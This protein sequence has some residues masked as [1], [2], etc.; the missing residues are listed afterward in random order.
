MYALRH[1]TTKKY[2][3]RQIFEDENRERKDDATFYQ[4]REEQVG[5]FGVK[6]RTQGKNVLRV[7]GVHP[8]DV[9]FR[10]L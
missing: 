7:L 6:D 2:L 4:W 10:P 5:A 8:K 9:S 3:H 1:K